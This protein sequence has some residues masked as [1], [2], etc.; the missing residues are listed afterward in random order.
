MNKL[1]SKIPTFMLGAIVGVVATA[2]SVA[3]AATYFKA[4][5]SS[6]KIVVDGAQAKLSESPMNING[7][8][9]LPVRDTANA[10]GYSVESVTSSQV[11]L[12]ESSASSNTAMPSNNSTSTTPNSS[13]NTNPTSSKKVNNLK[14]LYSTDDKLDAEKIRTALNNGTL[15][16]NA[17][18]ESS[19]DSLLHIVISEDN[20]E[21]Y[22]AIKR[23]AL[24]VDVKNKKGIT[25]LMLTVIN[26]N[27]F[28]F[29]ELK[30][31]KAD[32]DLVDASNKRA[33]DYADPKSTF[34]DSLKIYM[35]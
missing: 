13:T 18:D 4:T 15:D 22:K 32:P 28:Y 12:K 1:V 34:Y 7:K 24:N 3:G 33:I 2:G 8:L 11:T 17:T 5:Q 30:T 31:L 23:N 29:G 16:L 19:G 25:P 21:A 26:K 10:M 9:F 27:S 6:V 35:F 20:F 14:E